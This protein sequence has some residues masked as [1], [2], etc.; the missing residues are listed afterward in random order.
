MANWLRVKID[1]PSTNNFPATGGILSCCNSANSADVSQVGLAAVDL[2]GEL[3]WFAAD[4]PYTPRPSGNEAGVGAKSQLFY[5][6][7]WDDEQGNLW[8]AT[9]GEDHST[10]LGPDVRVNLTFMV[11]AFRRVWPCLCV[12][13]PR[14]GLRGGGCAQMS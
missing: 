9:L 14:K 1:T 11:P 12:V 4:A 7:R 6:T 2:T 13:S 10:S 5:S 3:T 8:T